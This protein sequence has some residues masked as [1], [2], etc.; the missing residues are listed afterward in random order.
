MP[1]KR[2]LIIG[3]FLNKKS[4]IP[5]Q[6]LELSGILKANGYEVLTVS[7]YKNKILRLLHTIVYIL[8]NRNKFDV[9]VVQVYSG[10]SL[11]WELVSAFLIKKFNKK[12]VLTI[13]GGAFPTKV[14][15]YPRPNLFLLHK[16][17]I[18][19]C[20]STFMIDALS[21]YNLKMVLVE[22][23]IEVGEYEYFKK[24]NLQP[25]IFWMRAL[26]PIY[27]PHMAVMVIKELKQTYNYKNVKLYMAGPDMGLKDEIK[28][29]IEQHGL[30]DNIE[31]V[32]FVN[33][34]KKLYFAKECSLYICTNNIDNAP[35]SFIEMMAMGLPIISTNIG[36]ITHLVTDHETALLV[37]AEDYKG[38]AEKVD[39]LLNH[40]DLANKLITNGRNYIY[41][42]SE[43]NVYN[44][45]HDL[46]EKL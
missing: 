4:N 17:D 6:A 18:I 10:L 46:F 35:V 8:Y 2:V 30:R 15:K 42:F 12:L 9:G 34:R 45:W 23:V 20:P 39:Y 24:E 37:D 16:A 7:K 5:T 21:E 28:A 14:K 32:G 43:K 40:P 13:H 29:L 33:M 22:N 38:M 26:S 31:L 36:G 19:T 44:K 25:V 1:H 27:N 3:L 11:V 41:N